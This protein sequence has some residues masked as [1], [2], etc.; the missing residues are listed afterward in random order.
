MRKV[1]WIV[2]C[3]FLPILAIAQDSEPS[4]DNSRNE[5]TVSEGAGVGARGQGLTALPNYLGTYTQGTPGIYAVTIPAHAVTATVSA[6]GGGGGG[7][8]NSGAA[9]GGGGAVVNFPVSVIPQQTLTITVGAGG[10]INSNG[11]DTI[12]NLGTLTIDC[13]AG[14]SSPDGITGGNGGSVNLSFTSVPGGV[15]GASG[16]LGSNGNVNFFAYSGAGGGAAGSI[17]GGVLL[18]TGGQG[19]G[20]NGGG[21][22][23]AF[24]NGGNYGQKAA[25]GAGGAANAAGGNGYVEV[26]FYK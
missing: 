12:I 6:V 16:Q 8:A 21:G 2:V 3:L 10:T 1:V 14:S 24:A 15:G 26:T 22:A 25:L 5:A 17:G 20:G 13:G 11:M 19:S 9:G 4:G 7:A 23:S 18:F